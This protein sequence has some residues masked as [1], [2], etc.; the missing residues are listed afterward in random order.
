MKSWALLLWGKG[1]NLQRYSKVEL[2]Q[3][4]PVDRRH[5]ACI[6]VLSH[7]P[8]ISPCLFP[9]SVFRLLEFDWT[10]ITIRQCLFISSFIWTLLPLVACALIWLFF[11][12]HGH[13]LWHISF[14]AQPKKMF[15]PKYTIIFS[16]FRTLTY[17][18]VDTV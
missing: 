18:L 1:A 8:F 4:K 5:V 9:L 15:S 17:F 12:L 11:F 13:K 2:I 16:Y 14:H 7:A 6:H 3:E 10:L